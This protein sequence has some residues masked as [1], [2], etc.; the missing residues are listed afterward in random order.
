MRQIGT[1]PGEREARA[2]ADHLLVREVGTKLVEGKD[3]WAVW[4]QDEDRVA[5]G[6]EELRAFL[7]APDDPR[8]AEAIAA[9]RAVRREAEKAES[10]HRK[11]TRDLRDRWEGPS[12]RR[13]P[14][15]IGL[16]AAC[17]A[18]AILTGLGEDENGKLFRGLLF[19]D[20]DLVLDVRGD[21]DVVT[22][23]GHGLREIRDG[24]VWRLVTP[25]FLHFGM[26]H[27]VFNL[28]WLRALG[29][30][31]ELRK[32]SWRLLVLVLA[33]A[34]ASNVGQYLIQAEGDEAAIFGGMS[35][36]VY[37]LFGYIWMKGHAHPEEGLAV[38]ANTVILMIAWFLIGTT[39]AF[40]QI[41]IAN[42]C[43]G[44]GLIAGMAFGL[45]RF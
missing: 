33:S 36:V 43:H 26:I 32:G 10:A 31:I 9:A 2:F 11:N 44:V 14:L 8:Y 23:I 4:V 38:P 15:T 25:I 35:G 24:Q 3:G 45:T 12:W 6:A 20:F 21:H 41:A 28:L 17:V 5:Q 19:S 30:G 1:I 16:I 27:L 22:A 29:G 37:A 13:Y 42:G 18:V 34:V 40:G 39:G 7:A